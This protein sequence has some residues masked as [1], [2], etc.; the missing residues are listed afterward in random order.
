MCRMR[1]TLL[2]LKPWAAVREAS[3]APWRWAV[4]VSVMA[5]ALRR[6]RRLPGCFV[7]GIGGTH[8]V[9]ERHG[10]AKLQVSSLR[11][12]RVSGKHLHHVFHCARTRGF[13]AGCV[14]LLVCRCEC[15]GQGRPLGSIPV[16][17][18]ATRR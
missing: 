15:P 18:F 2:R 8:R 6:L 10:V 7:L 11:R 1:L 9:G 16:R 4:I 5:R 13:A 3:V 12:V 17:C 14:Q